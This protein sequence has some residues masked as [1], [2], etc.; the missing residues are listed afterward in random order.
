MVFGRE[1]AAKAAQE[2]ADHLNIPEKIK[3]LQE[4][5]VI[6]AKE[7]KKFR[8]QTNNSLE[9]IRLEIANLRADMRVARAEIGL[10]VAGKTIEIVNS[11][12]SDFNR[13]VEQIAVN[14]AVLEHS[15]KTI[16]PSFQIGENTGQTS[17]T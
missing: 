3:G 16:G 2:I 14:V 1:K 10:E 15:V 11:V 6:I 8:D 17:N 5:Q 12:Q 7:L 4:A 9:S 13:R